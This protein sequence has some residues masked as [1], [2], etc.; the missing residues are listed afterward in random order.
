MNSKNFLLVDSARTEDHAGEA[1]DD[2]LEV[3]TTIDVS[4]LQE[5]VDRIRSRIRKLHNE[6][7]V[8][9]PVKVTID[10]HPVFTVIADNLKVGMSKQENID[11]TYDEAK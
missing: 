11:F 6:E 7:P 4:N 10:A 3:P 1:W 9:S 5:W 8:N 2:F